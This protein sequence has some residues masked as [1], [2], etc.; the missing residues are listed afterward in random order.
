MALWRTIVQTGQSD[1]LVAPF[2]TTA[3][4][5]FFVA[6]S[7]TAQS[8]VPTSLAALRGLELDLNA[9]SERAPEGMAVPKQA[10]VV[11]AGGFNKQPKGCARHEGAC[12]DGGARAG[13]SAHP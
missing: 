13:E 7:D 3:K 4:F 6:G 12:G 10:Q 2:D 1:E 8:T 5:R 11:T 9:Q